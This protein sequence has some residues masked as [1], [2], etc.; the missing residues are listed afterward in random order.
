MKIEDKHPKTLSIEEIIPFYIDDELA[1]VMPNIR[2]YRVDSGGL[3]YYYQIGLDE[4]PIFYLS[5]TSFISTVLPQG[6]HLIDWRISLGKEESEEVARI[7]AAYGT[8]M[9]ILIAGFMRDGY[10]DHNE[11][12]SALSDFMAFEGIPGRFFGPWMDDLGSDILAF[13]QFVIDYNV[14]PLAI[15]FPVCGEDGL[16]GMIDIACQMDFGG[17]RIVALVDN[18]SGRKGFWDEHA[19]QGKTY[20]R[21]WNGLFDRTPYEATHVFNWAPINWRKKPNYKLQDQTGAA[22]GKKLPLYLEIFKEDGKRTPSKA[23]KRITNTL[24]FGAPIQGRFE[25]LDMTDFVTQKIQND[26][27][28]V[29]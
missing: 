15:E 4:S 24:E 14:K 8:F 22:I 2:L 3:R 5:V 16:A 1:A 18:K 10:Y 11:T 12:P 9:H 17:K 26:G 27:R 7:A 29:G 20:Q 25:V 19:L 6:E 28:K 13:A 21:L 23:F